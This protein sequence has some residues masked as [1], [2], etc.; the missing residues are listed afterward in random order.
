MR[1]ATSVE[2]PIVIK[3]A[4]GTRVL[5]RRTSAPW[6]EVKPR[7]GAGFRGYIREDRLVV[8]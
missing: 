5:V 4:P 8:E 3:L 1:A 7:A 6:W 2:S